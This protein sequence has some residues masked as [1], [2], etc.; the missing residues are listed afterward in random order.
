MASIEFTSL[1]ISLPQKK[2]Q[3]ETLIREQKKSKKKKKKVTSLLP[4]NLFVKF[5]PSF[6]CV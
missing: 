1:N 6:A 2:S 5:V 3:K 4:S